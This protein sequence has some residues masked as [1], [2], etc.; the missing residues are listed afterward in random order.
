M[1][2]SILLDLSATPDHDS[3]RRRRQ[4]LVDVLAIRV[5]AV[6]CGVEQRS[7]M[8][9]FGRAHGCVETFTVYMLWNLG[10]ITRAAD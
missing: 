6:I 3:D 10:Q 4:R 5:M 7:E 1:A 2:T 8:E 9:E